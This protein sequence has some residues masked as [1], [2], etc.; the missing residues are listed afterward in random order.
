MFVH[1]LCVGCRHDDC[2]ARAP[3]GAN[4]T[5]QICGI[6][7]IVAHHPRARADRRPDVGL[8][9]LLSDPRFVLKPNLDLRAGGAAEQSFLQPRTKVS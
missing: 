7:A 8:G 2:G 9:S 6:V 4:C 1:C 5:E 3:C